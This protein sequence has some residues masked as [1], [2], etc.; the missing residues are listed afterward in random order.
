[1]ST[2]Y[3]INV[4]MKSRQF[5]FKGLAHALVAT[6]A[7]AVFILIL[8]WVI[9]YFNSAWQIEV[10]TNLNIFLVNNWIILVLMVLLFSVWEYL[11]PVFRRRLRYVKPLIDAIGLMF[12]LWLVAV[13]L[14]GLTIFV[15]EGSEFAITFNF[16]HEMF[17]GLFYWLFLLFLFVSYSKFFLKEK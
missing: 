7:F 12:G 8:S 14:K 1:M 4:E 2:D 3:Y 5:S 11:L 13:I 16:L 6:A 15:E 9:D 17:F 10:L